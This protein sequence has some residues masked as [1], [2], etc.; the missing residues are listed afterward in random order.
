MSRA[1]RIKLTVGGALVVLGVLLLSLP[2]QWIEM[3]LGVEPDGGS[4]ELERF[5]GLVPMV[6]GVALVAHAWWVERGRRAA[7]LSAPQP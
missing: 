5:V 6:I 1:S 7:S 2:P 3:L 4:G